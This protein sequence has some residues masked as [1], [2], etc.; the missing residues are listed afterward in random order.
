MIEVRLEKERVLTPEIV[1]MFLIGQMT[2]DAA[3]QAA[4]VMRFAGRCLYDIERDTFLTEDESIEYFHQIGL[5][6]VAGICD[7]V[8]SL[9]QESNNEYRLDPFK[10]T[11]PSNF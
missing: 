5:A 6:G 8:E 9:V 4:A 1:T 3:I 2:E 10:K 11:F 7:Q